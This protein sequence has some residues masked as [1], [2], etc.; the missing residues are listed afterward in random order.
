MIQLRND[1][2]QMNADPAPS[3]RVTLVGV[4]TAG[5]NVL[6]QMVLDGLTSLDM[7]VFDTDKQVLTGS[8]V[9]TKE[10]IGLKTT[11]GLGVGGDHEFA[12]ELAEQDREKIRLALEGVDLAIVVTGL[13]GGSGTGMTPEIL[14][15]L[16]EMDA[17]TIVLAVTP[18]SF[19]GSRRL[20]QAKAGT[21]KLRAAA[22]VV[23]VF[24]NERLSRI[25]EAQHNVREGFRAMNRILGETAQS[26]SRLLATRAL[27]QLSMADMQTLVGRRHGAEGVLE[28]CW[29]GV[30]VAS[31]VDRQKKVVEKALAGPLFS[32]AH[33]WKN[34]DR[35]LASVV[36]GPGMSVSDFQKVMQFL[37][38]ELP[39]EFP[40]VAGAAVDESMEDRLLLTLLV[41][42]SSEGKIVEEAVEIAL[43]EKESRA[44]LEPEMVEEP[45]VQKPREPLVA[46]LPARRKAA[47]EVAKELAPAASLGGEE[48]V[49]R[50]RRGRDR[51]KERKE[52]RYFSEQEEL[53]LDTKV[54]RGRFEK[55]VPTMFNG[56]NL[57]QPTFMRLKMRL[58]ISPES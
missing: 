35:I 56:Q 29:V 11:R 58:R 31:G 21:V 54:L 41:A 51:G 46:A 23:L 5:V 43:E 4:G 14:K 9:G 30:A 6:D 33:V 45:A 20:N 47:E 2:L 55:A 16:R 24:A 44:G 17:S 28:N 22:D 52:Q 42:R 38:R 34:G 27:M 53:P 39:V 7:I 13:G 15:V 25:P 37:Q 3:R 40:M 32:D 10:L 50:V 48:G 8:V 49:P 26:V 18:F 36:G 12:R 57:D 19:E 1:A